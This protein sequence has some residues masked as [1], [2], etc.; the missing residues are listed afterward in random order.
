VIFPP[1]S[2]S[3]AGCNGAN[4]VENGKRIKLFSIEKESSIEREIINKE[5]PK[6]NP[7]R[8]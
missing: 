5:S 2:T 4:P 6:K 8:I 3:I 7:H 1:K